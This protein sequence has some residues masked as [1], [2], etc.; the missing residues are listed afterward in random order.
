MVENYFY[1]ESIIENNVIKKLFDQKKQSDFDFFKSL[2]ACEDWPDAVLGFQIADPDSE[3]DKINRA[4]E[5][6]NLLILEDLRD[7]KFL[8]F[9]CG[10]GHA[11]KHA[12]ELAKVSVG[13]DLIKTGSLCWENTKEQYLLTTDFEKIKQKAPFDVIMIYDVLDHANDPLKI[14]HQAKKVLN[15]RGVIYLRC[16]PW[17]GRHGSH[18]FN[19]LNKAFVH[20]VFNE[21]E[22]K[23]LGLPNSNL[24]KFI[25]PLK[26]YNE[27]IKKSN[28]KIIK[29]ETEEQEVE[30]FFKKNTIIKNKIMKNWNIKMWND[31]CPEFQMRQ[32]F[33]D[34]VLK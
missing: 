17:C 5:I 14:L 31:S 33:V 6:I 24:N 11:C 12:A 10:E 28:L 2:L 18:Q 27:F 34:Y 13:Y 30:I 29:K 22:L 26:K 3:V 4:R 20:L 21:E 8:D 15:D 19:V 23:L 32:C 7:K 9:G 25:F 16:H 1:N